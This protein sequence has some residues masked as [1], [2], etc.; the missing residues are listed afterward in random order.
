MARYSRTTGRPV[1]SGR[2]ATQD[3]QIGEIVN[4]GFLKGLM[5]V[6]KEP[7]PGDYAP[8]AWHLINPRSGAKYRFVPHNGIEKLE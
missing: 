8:D 3:W 6:R 4:V 5:V 1:S 7:T 2:R